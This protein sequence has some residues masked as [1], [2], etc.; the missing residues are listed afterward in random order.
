MSYNIGV[1]IAHNFLQIVCESGNRVKGKKMRLR[2]VSGLVGLAMATLATVA[3]AVPIVLDASIQCSAGN[4]QNG[5]A[6]GDVTG[7]TGGANDCWG[8][9]NGNDPGPSGDGFDIGGMIFDF[10]AKEDT[11]GGL[12]GASIGL[13][14]S[15]AGGAPMGTW[16]FDPTLFSADAFLIVLKAANNP[17]Y[18]VWLFEGA[19]AD[20][21]SGDWSVAWGPDLSH[22]SI[23]AKNGVVVPEPGTLA[24][25]GI[26]L[27]GM[28]LFRR[29]KV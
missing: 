17:G 21:F 19:D 14:V 3:Q 7:N 18:G 29:K 9:I 28:G 1:I 26:G 25:L 16:E 6:I 12:S 2:I 10:I 8:T 27:A 5:I 13:D 23:Y 11:P 24:L 22:L 15:P 20:E 4:A